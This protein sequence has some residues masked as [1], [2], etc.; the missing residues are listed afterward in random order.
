MH[1]KPEFLNFHLIWVVA[2]LS[3]NRVM[4]RVEYFQSVEACN[5]KMHRRY[6]FVRTI[7]EYSRIRLGCLQHNAGIKSQLKRAKHCPIPILGSVHVIEQR[8]EPNRLAP[9]LVHGVLVIERR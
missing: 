2:V 1:F 8:N 4:R 5:H 3:P 6:F 9:Q 7:G